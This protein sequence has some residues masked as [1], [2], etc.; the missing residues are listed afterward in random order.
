VPIHRQTHI[1]VMLWLGFDLTQQE[2]RP[3]W[4]NHSGP[5]V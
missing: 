4:V 5:L 2:Y 1:G 3:Q